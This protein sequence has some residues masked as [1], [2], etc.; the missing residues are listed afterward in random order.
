[1]NILISKLSQTPIYEQIEKQVKENILSGKI[2]AGEQLPSIRGLARELKVGIIT[3]KRAYEEL[4]KAGIIVNIQGRGSFVKDIDVS[5]IKVIHLE[6]LR[7]R[8]V[9][10][11]DFCQASD[12]S[13]DE[14]MEEIK[15]L[16]GGEKDE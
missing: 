14:L 9:D 6:M 12:I 8:L 5:Q 1:M 7:E 11:K 15:Y 16:Y 13:M 2:T 4:E 10:I 3:V